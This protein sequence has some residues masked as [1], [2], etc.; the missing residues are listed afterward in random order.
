M[1]VDIVEK[2][3]NRLYAWVFEASEAILGVKKMENSFFE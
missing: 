3:W 1:M 2:S